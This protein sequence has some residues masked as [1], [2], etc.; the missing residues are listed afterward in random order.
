MDRKQNSL[1]AQAAQLQR[2]IQ[3]RE[4]RR[5]AEKA[6]RHEAAEASGEYGSYDGPPAKRPN[7]G[8]GNAAG[9]AVARLS[10]ISAALASRPAETFRCDLC[11]AVFPSEAP[12]QQHL[13]GPV[14]RR[15]VERQREAQLAAQ[16]RAVYQDMT[17]SALGAAA[18]AA[19]HGN[20]AAT[21][22]PTPQQQHQA[23][24]QQQ[25]QQPPGAM[26]GRGGGRGGGRDAGRGGGRGRGSDATAAIGGASG[27]RGDVLS[28]EELV[29]AATRSDEPLTIGGWAPPTISLRPPE[30]P[31]PRAPAGHAASQ[32]G[33]PLLQPLQQQQQ[34]LGQQEQQQQQQQ[35]GAQ[36]A[37]DNATTAAV[38]GAAAGAAGGGPSAGLLGLSYG[39]DDED[40]DA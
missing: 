4:Q 9:S 14:H 28:H 20:T 21:T 36:G 30:E 2:S 39:S 22:R 19:G 25:Q 8:S 11:Q 5:I 18:W 16:R 6:Q 17:E 27:R 26:A 10:E 3:S 12:Y 32:P 1:S 33:A 35:Q 37:D 34:P 24:Q 40:E 23:Q 29:A 13:A 38:A 7:P 15:A 31:Q